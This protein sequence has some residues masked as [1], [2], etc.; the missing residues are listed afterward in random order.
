M[1]TL[2]LIDLATSQPIKVVKM[3]VFLIHKV[4]KI[5]TLNSEQVCSESNVKLF[6]PLKNYCCF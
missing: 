2:L 5:F 1:V 3:C 6:I 4:Q